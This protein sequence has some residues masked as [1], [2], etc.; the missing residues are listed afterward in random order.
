MGFGGGRLAC[1]NMM[2]CQT[3]CCQRFPFLTSKKMCFSLLWRYDFIWWLSGFLIGIHEKCR[4]LIKIKTCRL[5]VGKWFNSKISCC[6]EKNIFNFKVMVNCT[7]FF[8]ISFLYCFNS[9]IFKIL[10]YFVTMLLHIHV[11]LALTFI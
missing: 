4:I 9:T 1:E 5:H 7:S 3:V 8:T 2:L 11:F 6:V 10:W